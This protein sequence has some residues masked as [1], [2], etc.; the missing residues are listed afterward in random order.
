MLG[1]MT[2]LLRGYLRFAR[3]IRSAM[4]PIPICKTVF[5]DLVA[6]LRVEPV[7]VRVTDE[8]G[9]EHTVT[10]DDLKFVHFVYDSIFIG[11]G[12]TTLPASI[13]AAG[14][15]DSAGP[16]RAG[17]ATLAA[18]MERSGRRPDRGPRA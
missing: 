7:T 15:G 6:E 14:E 3:P 17:S 8:A 16:P 9:E 2:A 18:S 13:Y 12:F 4:R 11:D 10:V 1:N 5:T